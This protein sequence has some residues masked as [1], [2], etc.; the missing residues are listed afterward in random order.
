VFKAGVSVAPVSNW[1]YYDNIYTERYMGTPET[2]PDGF[3]ANSPTTYTDQLRDGSLLLVHG[4]GDDNV[5]WQNSAELINALVRSN[6]QFD[7]MVYPDR[8]HGIY[9]GNTRYHLYK[10][11]T[12]FIKE[13][14]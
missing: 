8:N 2:N 13:N 11:M 14:L 5:H 6:K 12:T 4:T 1:K 10:K 3:D 9:G 7:L